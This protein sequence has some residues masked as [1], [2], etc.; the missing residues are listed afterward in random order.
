MSVVA[1]HTRTHTH[2]DT[3]TDAHTH[4]Q[5]HTHTHTH[6]HTHATHV[7]T[8]THMYTHTDMCTHRHVHTTHHHTHTHTIHTPHITTD[9]FF[10]PYFSVHLSP[11]QPSGRSRSAAGQCRGKWAGA[12]TLYT[13]HCWLCQLKDRG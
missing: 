10:K 8:H 13:V 6:T 9:T 2:C 5:H 7:H 3:H 12:P 1:A 4:T 11:A